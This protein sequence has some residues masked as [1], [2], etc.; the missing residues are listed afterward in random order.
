MFFYG[1]PE[2]CD[3]QFYKKAELLPDYFPTFE[4]LFDL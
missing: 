4:Y 1:R 2:V 3:Q